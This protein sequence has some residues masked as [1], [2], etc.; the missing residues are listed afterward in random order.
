MTKHTLFFT[1]FLFLISGQTIGQNT[2]PASS[3]KG[4]HIV[5][6]GETLYGI[7][8]K[9]KTSVGQV[10]AWNN[11]QPTGVLPI[12]SALKISAGNVTAS[13]GSVGTPSVVSK[14]T[15][16]PISKDLAGYDKDYEYK[17]TLPSVYDTRTKAPKTLD[18]KGTDAGQTVDAM[19]ATPNYPYF[20]TSGF[21]PFYHV[22]EM[23][24][25]LQSIGQ[26]YNL[27]VGDIMM[28][29]LINTEIKLPIG[30]KLILEDR[31]QPRT[32]AYVLDKQVVGNNYNYDY[33]NGVSQQVQP[34]NTVI[35][36]PQSAS[37]AQSSTTMSGDE[38]AMTQEINFL[39]GNPR[40]YITY[41]QQY[42]EELNKSG[43]NV[44]ED[45]QTA[46]ELIMELGGMNSLS[47]L[48]PAECI[49]SAAKKHGVEMQSRGLTD[50]VG[51]DGSYPWDRIKREC[52][53]S[54]DGNENLVGGP[55]NIRRAVV[56]LLVDSGISTRGHRRTLL[57]PDWNYIACYKV[58]T[59]AD[60]PN[61]WIQNFGN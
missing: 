7:S 18:A 43:Q 23:G 12:C 20:E 21:V 51:A 30:K 38:N 22:A 27:P 61:V 26:A 56:I 46:N 9:Y 4:I 54:R 24:E 2:C 36:A 16:V 42:I 52:A 45:V 49:Y 47:I 55:E 13:S 3:T 15:P 35:S 34:S 60:M 14:S 39:R 53:D 40:G 1:L 59:V 37:N 6:K 25:T 57:N 5:Q 31:N 28:M 17:K 50:H 58:G 19:D 32:E 11:I 48:Q 29:N 8:R 33:S 44:T 41:I 10:C